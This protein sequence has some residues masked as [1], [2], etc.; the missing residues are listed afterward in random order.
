MIR[1]RKSAISDQKNVSPV[2]LSVIEKTPKSGE[3]RT[4]SVT[5]IDD[6]LKRA[7]ELGAEKAKIIDTDTIVVEKWVRWKTR[8]MD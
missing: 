4:V 1:A 5:K 7:F 3:E 2:K 8:V 6:L